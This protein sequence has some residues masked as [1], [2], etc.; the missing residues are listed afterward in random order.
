MLK[1]ARKFLLS[2]VVVLLTA[3]AHAGSYGEDV[4]MKAGSAFANI[5]LGWVEIPKNVLNT[6]NDVNIALGVTGG[7]M[8]GVL[9]TLG[10]ITAGTFDLVSAPL[11]TEPIVSPTFVWQDFNNDTR[12]TSAF[13]LKK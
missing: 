1:H 13:R 11:P 6:T 9:H 5:A 7:L 2:T 10:R 8:K 3:P 4:G 12:Y